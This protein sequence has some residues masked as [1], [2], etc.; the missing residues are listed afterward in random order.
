MVAGEFSRT[1]RVLGG[2]R[3][4][5]DDTPIGSHYY[6]IGQSA[7]SMRIA[8]ASV[9]GNVARRRRNLA[10]RQ[11]FLGSE[12]SGLR[13]KKRAAPRKARLGVA[14][15]GKSKGYLRL[16]RLRAIH[17]TPAAPRP[18]IARVDGSGTTV[19]VNES[20]ATPP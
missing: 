4:P 12:H 3:C 10:F 18:T 1:E 20:V 8:A 19:R 13:A 6:A 2:V 5:A 16:R 15:L 11:V 17:P 9:T 7:Q 14:L